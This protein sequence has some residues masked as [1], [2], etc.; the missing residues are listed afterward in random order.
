MR[1]RLLAAALVG[2]VTFVGSAA[3]SSAAPTP[4]QLQTAL[5][6]PAT[7]VDG[8]AT[9]YARVADAGA[10]A[11]RLVADWSTVAPSKPANPSDPTSAG[12]DWSSVD[13][14]VQAAAAAHLQPI[15][16]LIDAP[17]WAMTS[18]AA[19]MPATVPSASDYGQF[20]LAA[21]T[22]YDGAGSLP[23]VTYWDVWNEPNLTP[24]F[25]PQFLAGSPYSPGWYRGMVNALATS[26]K[27]VHADNLVIAGET[28]PFFDNTSSV[29]AVDPDWGPL[30]FMRDLLCL[31]ATLTP[32][33]STPAE[34]D[35]WA[36]HPYPSGGPDHHATLANDA[37]IADMPKVSAILD[38]AWSAGHITAP[39]PPELWATEI[40]WDTNP[41]NAN[42]VPMVLA[43]RWTAE[44]LYRLWSDGV[45]LVTW[46]SLRDY[47]STSQYQSGLYYRGA[48]LA[49]DTPKPI[50]AA[51]RF[52]FVAYPTEGGVSVWGRT[53]AGQAG[54]VTVQQLTGS[55]PT[56]T[57]IGTLTPN[58]Y[59]I[60]TGVLSTSSHGDVRASFTTGSVTTTSASFWLRT[61]PDR[62]IPP[63]GGPPLEPP[64]TP[65][66][67]PPIPAHSPTGSPR[68]TIP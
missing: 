4:S 44:A 42:G 45:S 67:R 32:T 59:G 18:P 65:R 8:S 57:T 23:R 68:P 16:D 1:A 43:T 7:L 25:T 54:T 21:A 66:P 30:S 46:F 11:I 33:C 13:R 39:A 22:R 5:L 37:S 56:W 64:P 48:T 6:D 51:F 17:A 14:Q 31:S 60:V 53:P 40:G 41:P 34:F 2:C 61:V 49:A 36:H 52:P 38:A 3:G 55:P 47:P 63:W 50:L 15:L 12:Y 29:T 9:A 35:I 27:S 26:V 62:T 20:A 24:D 58:S 28:A 19:G 10:T